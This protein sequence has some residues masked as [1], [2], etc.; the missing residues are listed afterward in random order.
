MENSNP[1]PLGG[2]KIMALNFT[3]CRLKNGKFQ[4]KSPG[5]IKIMACNIKI[6]WVK[7]GKFESKSTK[8]HQNNASETQNMLDEKLK[9]WVH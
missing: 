8:R 7:N 6:C 5:G 3:K 2:I 9:I 4:S 1:G